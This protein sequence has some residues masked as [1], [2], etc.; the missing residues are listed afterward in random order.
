MKGSFP[1]LT[2]LYKGRDVVMLGRVLVFLVCNSLLMG[3]NVGRASLLCSSSRSHLISCH[4]SAVSIIEMVIV[5]NC[6]GIK[7]S[8]IYIYIY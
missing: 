5:N 4:L 2:I 6:K 1:S 8:D 3:P 7:C